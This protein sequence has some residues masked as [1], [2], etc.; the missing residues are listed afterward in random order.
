MTNTPHPF[1]TSDR[2]ID[3]EQY[4][5]KEVANSASGRFNRV[6][7]MLG[8]IREH[9]IRLVRR[10]RKENVYA[11]LP[12]PQEEMATR[13]FLKRN[14]VPVVP[15][16]RIDAK[17]DLYGTDLTRG[18]KA[19]VVSPE[20]VPLEAKELDAVT[21]KEVL[22]VTPEAREEIF[23]AVEDIARRCA[24]CGMG[25]ANHDGLYFVVDKDGSN[26]H[27]LAGDYKH[28]RHSGQPYHDLLN[29][30]L[31]ECTKALKAPQIRSMFGWTVEDVD[32]WKEKAKAVTE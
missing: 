16:L 19:F 27:V 4:G 1:E 2:S 17:G 10:H 11:I 22:H 15:T 25:I 28:F 8:G 23:A 12:T 5:L 29:F 31:E 24:R 32:A 3:P 9:V 26:L 30:N 18:G 14:G 20:N 6:T 13:L 21:R 7:R